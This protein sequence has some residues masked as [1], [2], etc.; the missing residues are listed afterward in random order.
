MTD[1]P[2]QLAI[3]QVNDQ[4]PG[5][6]PKISGPGLMPISD[7]QGLAVVWV[8]P[9]LILTG[10]TRTVQIIGSGY[11]GDYVASAGSFTMDRDYY[12]GD[13]VLT[14]TAQIVTNGYRIF[15]QGKLNLLNCRVGAIVNNGGNGASAVADVAG[16]LTPGVPFNTVG[17]S[18]NGAAGVNGT[19]GVGVTGNASFQ[20]SAN[21]GQSG[22]SGAGGAGSAGAGGSFLSASMRSNELVVYRWV[23]AFYK[24]TA[25]GLQPTGGGVSGPSGGTGAGDGT[26]KGGAS[27]AAASGAGLLWI[28]GNTI[29]R[30]PN[31]PAGAIQVLGGNG[32]NGGN[33]TAGN[34]GGGSGGPGA[35]G[36]FFFGWW[37]SYE[38]SEVAGM[39]DAS[40]GAGGNGGNGHGTGVGGQAGGSGESGLVSIGDLSTGMIIHPARVAGTYAGAA[41]S[42]NA[43]GIGVAGGILRVNL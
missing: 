21:G 40:G 16:G 41:A 26:N 19:T 39:V 1:L 38:G 18:G 11:D 30:G 33:G 37:I 32:G 24:V 27:A 7:D 10:V 28:S 8:N 23:D 29:L 5:T 13:I 3:R 2:L 17:G 25:A 9:N 34:T 42:G 6:L 14:G 15:H 35:G 22:A 4:I 36:G 43:G 12:W 31:T 20:Q